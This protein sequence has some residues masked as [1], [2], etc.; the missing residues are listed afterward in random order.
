MR[1]CVRSS[2]VSDCRCSIVVKMTSR[3]RGR[4]YDVQLNMTRYIHHHSIFR[5]DLRE[6]L[7]CL[8]QDLNYCPTVH[9]GESATD[10]TRHIYSMSPSNSEVIGSEY[11]E[12]MFP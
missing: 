2:W 6:N 11:I 8:L 12:D 10:I 3:R 4:L 1:D 5:S 9:C 7:K